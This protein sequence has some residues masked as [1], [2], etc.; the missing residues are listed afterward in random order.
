MN[1]S[2]N[3]HSFVSCTVPPRLPGCQLPPVSLVPWKLQSRCH[4]ASQPFLSS[5]ASSFFCRW[6]VC[7]VDRIDSE[8]CPG[9]DDVGYGHCCSPEEAKLET[10]TKISDDYLLLLLA[11]FSS[12]ALSKKKETPITQ[13]HFISLMPEKCIQCTYYYVGG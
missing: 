11:E 10:T 7:L 5:V 4:A 2:R 13:L 3:G 12:D 8:C 9:R 1:K 6:L